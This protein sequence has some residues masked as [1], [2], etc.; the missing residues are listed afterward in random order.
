MAAVAMLFLFPQFFIVSYKKVSHFNELNTDL[1]S[2]TVPPIQGGPWILEKRA[3]FSKRGG[4]FRNAVNKII[5]K[6][7]W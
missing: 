6:S 4:A 7:M 1:V 5:I 3:A 2:N